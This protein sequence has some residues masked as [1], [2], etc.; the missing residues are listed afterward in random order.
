MSLKSPIKVLNSKEARSYPVQ[1][2]TTAGITTGWLVLFAILLTGCTGTHTLYSKTLVKPIQPTTEIKV[3][4]LD[5]KLT[6][7]GNR[8]I[9]AL[10]AVGYDDLPELLRERVPMVFSMNGLQATY[11]ALEKMNFGQNEAMETVKWAATRSGIKPPLLVIQ[12]VNGSIL[13]DRQNGSST[14]TLNMHANLFDG[15]IKTR[16]WTGQFQNTLSLSLLGRVGFDNE[17]ADN[18]LKIILE[19]MSEDGIIKLSENKAVIPSQAG[20]PQM[21]QNTPVVG[22]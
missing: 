5:N 2:K 8:P 10:Q 21:Q 19:Q 1:Q 18:M 3:L 16:Q 12:V 4:Y 14:V 17:F 22:H 20:D 13:S 15:G 11:A 7:S 6:G 9:G